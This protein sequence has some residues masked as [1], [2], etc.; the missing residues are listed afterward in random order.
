[1]PGV[2]KELAEHSLHVRPDAKPVKQPLRCFAEEKRKVIGEEIARLLVAGF[3]ME[4]FYPDWLAN[5]VLVLKKNNSWR[6]CI[7]YTSLNK[8]CPK[9]PFALPRIDQVIDSTPGCDLL[10]FLDAYSCYHQISLYQ[11]DQI[12]TSFITPY[13]AYCYVTMPFGLKNAGA[14]YQRM[15][16]QCLQEQIGRKVHAYV[17][18]VV[19]KTKQSDT[20]LD[21]LKETFTNLPCYRMKL[22]PEKC[23]FDVPAGDTSQTYI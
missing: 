16:Q 4:V 20:L 1:M 5:P 7:D 3:I 19:V 14:T 8:A 18:D 13:G 9:D 10:S 17:D 23:T 11:P 6:M 21:D 15:M 22:N 12:K 2:L